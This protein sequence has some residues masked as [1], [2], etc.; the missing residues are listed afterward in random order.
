ML[1]NHFENQMKVSAHMSEIYFK[2]PS[3]LAIQ[4]NNT[5]SASPMYMFILLNHSHCHL[6]IELQK[7]FCD[8]GFILI[9]WATLNSTDKN[10]SKEKRGSVLNKP[11]IVWNFFFIP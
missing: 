5:S 11:S 9:I 10:T 4:N 2:L 6:I 1:Q 8:F 3:K 7:P